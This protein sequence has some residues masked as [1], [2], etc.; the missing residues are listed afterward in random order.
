MSRTKTLQAARLA[1]ALLSALFVASAT[2]LDSLDLDQNEYVTNIIDI[3][4]GLLTDTIEVTVSFING[5]EG[6][7]GRQLI[8]K[9]GASFPIQVIDVTGAY[10][11]EWYEIA[12]SEPTPLDDE[13]VTLVRSIFPNGANCDMGPGSPPC[14]YVVVV[15]LELELLT[16][17]VLAA[18]GRHTLTFELTTGESPVTIDFSDFFAE[19]GNVI[20]ID[21]SDFFE[22]LGHAITLDSEEYLN[23][24][25]GEGP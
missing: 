13:G 18:E 16:D 14:E 17:T 23:D 9:G 1:L 11:G 21:F 7:A 10:E 25:E 20:E 22:S 24:L 4:T 5:D 2:A 8:L 3:Q 12:L 19:D 6:G 15:T